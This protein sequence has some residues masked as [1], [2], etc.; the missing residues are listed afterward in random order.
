MSLADELLADLDDIEETTESTI[1][2]ELGPDAKKRRLELQLEEGNG[3]S[4]ELENDLDITKIS[5]SAQKLPSEVANKF[6]DNNENI[7]QLLNS[8]RLRDIIEGTEK[9]KG[10]E[11]QAITGNIEDD[12]EYHLIVDS[13]SIAMEIDDE[14]LRLH[15][16]VK[17]WY[18]DRFPE[19]SSLVLNAFD[20]CKTVSSLLNDL[21][22]SKTKLSFLPSATV[23]VIA[24]TATTTVG[25]PLPD[26]MIKNV[27]NCCEAIQQLGE[28][29][30]KIIEYVQ[31]RIS[32]VAPNL[33][34]VVGSTTAANLIGIAGGLTRLGKF[35][36]CNLPAL[37]K[38]RLTTI[39][40]NN[41]AVSGDYGFL[42]MSEIVQKT[43]PD[44]RKQAIRMTA[45]KVALAARIDSIHEYPDGSFGISARKEVERKIEKLLEPPSQKPTVALPVPDD[46]PKRRR[47]G[48]R[49]RKMKEQY[50]VTELRRLQNRVAFGKEEAE[51]F[52][53]DETEGLGMLGQE[54][55]GKIRAVSIDSRT[56]L[57]L[58]KAR[59]AQLQSM[60]QKNPLAA[61]GLQS[62]LSFTPI[63]G[64]EL[65]NPLLQR[66]QKVEEANKWFRDGVFT[67]IKKDSNEPKNKFS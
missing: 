20:Y 53:F 19:L 41:P 65:V 32:V 27:K 11:K 7:Y 31:S 26:E 57:R 55:E 2:D 12:L 13:N 28:E 67:Q 33:S 18:H 35:P 17:E 36:A 10:T 1:T 43:P 47:G 45:A 34:A 40:I 60:A 5:D 23:M 15:R 8:T 58:P 3:I 51:V 29:K 25:K 44:V 16:L 48:R 46:R 39:G 66:Q 24:T 37:G 64:I 59:K 21:D 63:Q 22:N 42:Y 49:I 54:G 14:I 30:Q 61:S 56:K 38:R 62:S 9:Y 50:A 52:N 6:N 4:A